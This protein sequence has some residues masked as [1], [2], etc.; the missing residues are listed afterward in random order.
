[1]TTGSGE[2]AGTPRLKIPRAWAEITGAWALAIA[3]PIFQ[4][5]SSGPDSFTMM[6]A[7]TLDLVIFAAVSILVVPTLLIGAELLLGL[8]SSTGRK[9]LHALLLGALLSLVL[10]QALGSDALGD[11]VQLVIFTSLAAAIA[12]AYLRSEFTRNMALLLGLAAPV[13]AVAFLL[14][15]PGASV[16][17]GGKADAAAPTAEAHPPVV[18]LVLDEFPLAAL[19]SAPDQIDRARFPNFAQLADQSSW[20]LNARTTGDVTT[21]AVPA[22]LSGRPP[23]ADSTPPSFRDHED[24]LF[25]RLAAAGYEIDATETVTDLCPHEICSERGGTIARL[26]KIAAN[27]VEFGKPLPERISERYVLP[28]VRE[29]SLPIDPPPSE[30]AD[31]FVGRIGPGDSRLEYQ[32]LILPH[33]P[34]IYLPDGRDYIGPIAPGLG[35]VA[36]EKDQT[37]LGSRGLTDASFQQFMLQ[38][39]YVDRTVGRVI[40]KMKETGIWEEA[41]LVV[42]ADHGSAFRQGVSRRYL[43]ERNAGWVLPVPLFVKYPGQTHGDK[44]DADFESTALLNDMLDGLGLPTTDEAPVPEGELRAHST[45]KGDMTLSSAKVRRGFDAAVRYRNESFPS[46]SFFDLTGD[47]DLIGRRADGNRRLRP[48]EAEMTPSQPNSPADL[49]SGQLPAY[50]SGSTPRKGECERKLAIALNGRVALTLRPWAQGD[51]CSFA[52]VLDPGLFRDGENE[53]TAYRIT[54]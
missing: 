38:V 33:I 5:A 41:M 49:S 10:W 31:R 54:G 18:M 14:T 24:N 36:G 30:E 9:R 34:W 8:V 32:H 40:R 2:A 51:Q 21:Q 44:I 15:G 13:T 1:V 42:V 3:W 25:T 47:P 20:Y 53:V 12:I 46:D 37:W 48:I 26:A 19:Q 22:L 43:T 7:D 27:G 28:R 29:A 16:T 11:A 4:G 45:A 35:D 52:G 50:V 6:R 39:G 23:H 17:L